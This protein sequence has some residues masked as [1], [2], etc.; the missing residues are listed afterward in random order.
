MWQQLNSPETT[1]ADE[2]LLIPQQ[3]IS[4]A[5]QSSGGLIAAASQVQIH[6]THDRGTSDTGAL[7]SMNTQGAE[8]TNANIAS[9]NQEVNESC[10]LEDFPLG[11]SL[12]L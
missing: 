10:N 11:M 1:R 9:I 5:E 3:E 8:Y 4:D 2:G 7:I 12:T 6:P